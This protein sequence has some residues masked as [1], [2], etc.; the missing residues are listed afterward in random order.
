MSNLEKGKATPISP[1]LFHLYNRNEC[2][3]DGEMKELVVAR[4]YLEF[5]ISPETVAHPDVVEI[6]SKRE[7]LSSAE[8]RKILGAS[9]SS[10]KKSTYCSLDGKS[11]VRNPDWR[12][13][14]M[15][16]F[17]FE[18]DLFRRIKEELAVLQGQYSKMEIVTKGASKLLGDYKAGNIFK[19]LKKLKQ[20]DKSEIE[21]YNKKLRL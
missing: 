21:A 9:P 1:Y 6:E 13:I 2:L 18:E 17:D 3:R 7:L 8:Q 15:G 14:M 20:E 11:P 12:S 10:W 5:G 19:E 16:S 4:K